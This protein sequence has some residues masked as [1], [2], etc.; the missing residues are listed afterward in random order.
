MMRATTQRCRQ[1][2]RGARRGLSALLIA[3]ALCVLGAC[4]SGPKRVSANWREVMLI[5]AADA[6]RNSPVAVDIVLISDQKALDQIMTLSAAQ[7]FST[8]GDLLATFADGVRCKGWEIVPGQTLTLGERTP[9]AG[10]RLLAALVFARYASAGAH[11]VRIDG[12]AGRLVL[13]FQAEDFTA[14]VLK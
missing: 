12:Y 4:G 2:A 6:N 14:R 13:T 5:A 8:R 10:K 1:G 3:G 11:R 9:F 7:W